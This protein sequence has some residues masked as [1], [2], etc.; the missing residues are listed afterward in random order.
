MLPTFYYFFLPYLSSRLA[1][2]TAEIETECFVVQKYRISFES[3]FVRTIRHKF[4]GLDKILLI[5]S[6]YRGKLKFDLFSYLTSGN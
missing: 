3:S 1:T 2:F 6:I 5:Q 4:L